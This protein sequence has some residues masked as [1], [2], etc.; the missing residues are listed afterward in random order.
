MSLISR[1]YK[2]VIENWL[3]VEDLIQ[4][5]S[6]FCNRVKRVQ[7]LKIL[8]SGV[9]MN[10]VSTHYPQILWL[11][12]RKILVDSLTI[13]YIGLNYLYPRSPPPDILLPEF[14]YFFN[15]LASLT[16]NENNSDWCTFLLHLVCESNQLKHLEV[17][18]F[19]PRR[20]CCMCY[21]ITLSLWPFRRALKF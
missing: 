13:L 9:K 18:P 19:C 16:I 11:I 17:I 12:K 6:A 21:N 14:F 5:D 7:Y 15:E 2:H 8:F 1:M 3:S 4:F 10:R 20:S